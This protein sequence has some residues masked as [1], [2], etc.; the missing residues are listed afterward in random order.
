MDLSCAKIIVSNSCEG[1]SY[2]Q[3][4]LADLELLGDTPRVGGVDYFT[5]CS[6]NDAIFC[7]SETD[8]LL[9]ERVGPGVLVVIAELGADRALEMKLRQR[10]LFLSSKECSP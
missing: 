9:L 8:R 6:R 3:L 10:G 2:A 4:M 5:R 7:D 1:R